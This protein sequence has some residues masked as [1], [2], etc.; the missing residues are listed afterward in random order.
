[1]PVLKAAHRV[2]GNGHLKVAGPP[3]T[4]SPLTELA[5]SQLPPTPPS[6]PSVDYQA[7]LLSLSDEYISA[8][9]SMS[10]SLAGGEVPGDKLDEYYALLS[11]GMSCLESVLN[12]YRILDARKEARIRLR[13][14]SLI[15][16]ETDNDMD[17]EAILSKG[18][19]LCERA[20]LTDPKYSMH[21]LLS[22]IWFKGGQARAAMKAV[23]KLIDEVEKLQ[24]THWIY[25]FRFLRVSFGLQADTTHQEAASLVKHLAAIGVTAS[26]T[27]AVAVIIVASALEALVHLRTHT[28]D[29]VD[30]AQRALAAARTH[31]LSAEMAAMSQARALLD[32]AD[33]ACHLMRLNHEQATAKLSDLRRNLDDY[34]EDPEQSK[35]GCWLLPLSEFA[36]NSDDIECD[37]SGILKQT[38][39][40]QYGLSM[41]WLTRTQATTLGFL[42]SG[43]TAVQKA[44]TEQMPETFLGEGI[45]LNKVTL[46]HNRESLSTAS[47][48]AL[49][50]DRM[51][52]TLQAY[53]VF[54]RCA[55]ADW[56]TAMKGMGSIRQYIATARVTLD[57]DT[58]VLVDYL[59]AISKHGLGHLRQALELYRSPSLQLPATLDNKT[60]PNV[61]S[62]HLKVLALLNSILILRKLGASAEA[63]E[64]LHRVE[65]MCVMQ[66]SSN[67]SD[68]GNRAIESAF[69]ALKSTA[70][71]MT[72]VKTKHFIQLAIGAAQKVGNDRLLNILMNHMTHVFFANIVGRQAEQS[73]K[74]GRVLAKRSG[75][76]LWMA[77]ADRMFSETTE[78]SGNLAEAQ[79]ALQQGEQA[80]ARLPVSLKTALFASDL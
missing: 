42:L 14:A 6:V 79:N 15:Y 77:V 50:Q 13:L 2:N 47:R 51:R 17:A 70:P 52:I 41:S 16:E 24:L 58:S 28:P 7:T 53:V 22:R 36:T 11:T 35:D 59:D 30:L 60:I 39:M 62:A 34:Y 1:M 37:T 33:L 72:I 49:W 18:I 55:R 61:N 64:L 26:K 48:H 45:S 76:R 75:D 5:S 23:D 66:H 27:H 71:E 29:S 46:E 8:A 74:V 57:E 44:N 80:M 20:R 9:Y 31:Q 65:P 68:Y 43:V 69:H 4:S 19:A 32:A 38:S 12:N 10:T 3:P 54:S 21:H 73:A 78:K 25:A 56:E 67:G 63:D 40:G